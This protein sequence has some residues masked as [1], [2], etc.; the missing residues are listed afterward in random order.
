[1]IFNKFC[2][3]RLLV[4]G[5]LYILQAENEEIHKQEIEKHETETVEEYHKRILT[6]RSHETGEQYLKRIANL[7]KQKPDLDI[8]K[9]DKFTKFLKAH[10]VTSSSKIATR[11]RVVEVKEEYLVSKRI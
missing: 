9:E 10:I 5:K 6:K 1:M 8:W 11:R 2:N 4:F 7:R 3:E